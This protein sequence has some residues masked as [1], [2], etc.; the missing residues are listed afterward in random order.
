MY[1]YNPR[2]RKKLYSNISKMKSGSNSIELHTSSTKFI[3]SLLTLA[4]ITTIFLYST[5]NTFSILSKNFEVSKHECNVYN[6]NWVLSDKDPYYTNE[7]KCVIDER[8]NCIK[9]GRPDTE[10][11]KWRWKPDEC[12]LNLFDSFKFLELVRNKTMAFVGDS[13]ARN[14]MQSLVCLLASAA[15]PVDV[16]YKPDER[17]RRWFYTDYNFTVIALWSPLLIK[18]RDPNPN[19]FT[20]NS[21][22]NLY[23]D[24][25]DETWPAQVENVDIIILSAGQWFF[26]PFTYYENNT[27][28]G[29]N[30]CKEE[31]MPILF[32][33]YAYR[34]AFRTSFRTILGLKNFT[35]LT[36]LRTFSPSHFENGDWN[37]GGSCGR[38][39]PYTK[40][41]M[42][43]DWYSLQLYT[44]QVEEFK[45]AKSLGVKKGL[46]FQL[47]DTTESTN[48]RAD[49]H[50]NHYGYWPYESKSIADCV[51]WCLPGPIDTWNE[52][53]LHELKAENGSVF[54]PKI[55]E[56]F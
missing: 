17:F 16:S 26:R 37:N 55:Q 31:N 11:L 8:Q 13:V 4:F 1:I 52:F 30:L 35:G 42:K 49:G 29:C 53:L 50:P 3:I 5:N 34:M 44:A 22:M 47:L 39:Q 7:T 24:E 20:R 36:L 14:Q 18:T 15:E 19:N 45:A 38:T 27:V 56:K 12:E 33:Y 23:L 51:H 43:L 10:F 41:E 9:Y 2:T 21:R 48:L 54:D 25:A 6:G 40:E 46:R 32:S 28:I